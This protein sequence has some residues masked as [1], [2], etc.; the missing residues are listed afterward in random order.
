MDM[1]EWLNQFLYQYENWRN[2]LEIG[3]KVTPHVHQ[4]ITDYLRDHPLPFPSDDE[5]GEAAIRLTDGLSPFESF[6]AG[7]EFCR[8]KME[9]SSMEAKTLLDLAVEIKNLRQIVEKQDEY[10][11]FLSIEL[12]NCELI[13]HAREIEYP[14]ELI[15][16]KEEYR[17]QIDELK[18]KMEGKV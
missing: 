5:A 15:E 10:I 9:E 13:L 11:R 18:T 3:V 14:V 12:E 2:D 6:I 7:V 8:E 16:Q 4:F 1:K 17:K